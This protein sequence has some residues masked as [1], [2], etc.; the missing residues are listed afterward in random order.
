MIGELRT[1]RPPCCFGFDSRW[2]CDYC[3]TLEVT[4]EVG[5][6]DP[7]TGSAGPGR[8]GRAR[9]RCLELSRLERATKRLLVSFFARPAPRPR[10]AHPPDP[11]LTP[12]RCESW[13]VLCRQFV[14]GPD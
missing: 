2:L 9:L 13:G 6:G 4:Q 1:R 11:F 7:S 8:P 3:V 5:A 12:S 10:P 14:W